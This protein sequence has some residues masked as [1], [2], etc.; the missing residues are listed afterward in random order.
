MTMDVH[1]LAAFQNGFRC[2]TIHLDARSLFAKETAR[3]SGDDALAVVSPDPGGVKRAQLFREFLEERLDRPVGA[4]FVEK[5]RSAGLVS[6]QLL[7]GDV[8]GVTALVIDDLI[9]TGGTMTRAA[10]ACL[11]NGASRVFALAT[12]GLFVGNAVQALNDPALAG[13]IV[14][15]T[16][17]AFRVDAA[18]VGKRL[19]IISAAP[20]FAEAIRRSSS[21]GSIS[22]LLE[23]IK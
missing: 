17:P 23:P 16:V 22:D 3:I 20:L 13:T 5:R 6:G 19:E 9:S 18:L 2:R 4:A 21:G 14:T 15:D 11:E 10:R 12:H 1:N 8:A 7:V